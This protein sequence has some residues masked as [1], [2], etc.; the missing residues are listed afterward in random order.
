MKTKKRPVAVL[1]AVMLALA[2]VA[3]A[4]A[5]T[6]CGEDDSGNGGIPKYVHGLTTD[7]YWE[8]NGGG[9]MNEDGSLPLASGARYEAEYA[10]IEGVNADAAAGYSGFVR[11]RSGSSNG[12]VLVRL[13]APGNKISFTVTSDRAE[14][15]VTLTACIAMLQYGNPWQHRV[16]SFDSAYNVSVNGEAFPQTGVN[17]GESGRNG[18]QYFEMVEVA[19]KIDLSEGKNVIT[20]TVPELPD[21][22]EYGD[23]PAAYLAPNFD[24]ITITAKSAK[25]TYTPYYNNEMEHK[26]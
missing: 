10:V 7:E 15:N 24:Y 22:L 8:S 19:L 23:N 4:C 26:S 11:A 21:E 17:F 3:A 18:E 1:L 2:L 16:A 14:E 5:L 6:G 12:Y 25:M 9:D 20:F 13:S